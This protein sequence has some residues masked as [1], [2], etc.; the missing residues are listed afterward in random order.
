MAA[1]EAEPIV[2]TLGVGALSV[3]VRTQKFRGGVVE[4]RVRRLVRLQQVFHAP[5]KGRVVR[6]SLIQKRR[7]FGPRRPLQGGLENG[8]DSLVDRWLRHFVP[9]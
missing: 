2:R 5:A 6:A 3:G 9:C 8:L 7:P 4:Q 1:Q